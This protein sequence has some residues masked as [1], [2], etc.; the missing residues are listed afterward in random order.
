[1]NGAEETRFHTVE[2][3]QAAKWVGEAIADKPVWNAQ[4]RAMDGA[5]Y[6]RLEGVRVPQTLPEGQIYTV[7]SLLLPNGE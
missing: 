2:D 4:S 6:N 1:M 3:W 5:E 7:V